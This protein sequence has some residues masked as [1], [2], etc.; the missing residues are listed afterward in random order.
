MQFFP[1]QFLCFPQAVTAR[2]RLTAQAVDFSLCSSIAEDKAK[3]VKKC[4]YYLT[5][6]L[7]HPSA[8]F[9]LKGV[10]TF[11]SI[12]VMVNIA[13]QWGDFP[14]QLMQPLLVVKEG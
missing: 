7:I 5:Q 14:L 6:S 1:Q 9:L 4:N 12:D 13:G 3:T 10:V 2:F 11:R 8:F